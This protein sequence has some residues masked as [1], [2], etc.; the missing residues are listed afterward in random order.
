MS[1]KLI[2]SILSTLLTS[3]IFF[4]PKSAI[5]LKQLASE[6]RAEAKNP[7]HIISQNI[8]DENQGNF[9]PQNREE[10]ETYKGRMLGAG[11]FQTGGCP[12]MA[13]P[14]LTTFV[15]GNGTESFLT[16]TAE[17]APTFWFY[18]PYSK[19]F[20]SELSAEF[21][22]MDKKGGTELWTHD[23]TQYPLEKKGIFP[24]QIPQGILQQFD[25][26]YYWRFK[27]VC[28]SSQQ[29]IYV[30]GYIKRVM[31]LSR[32]DLIVGME[33]EEKVQLY[34]QNG[35]W[36]EFL[37]TY[38][39]EIC[40]EDVERTK[41]QIKLELNSKFIGL[42]EYSENYVASIINYCNPNSVK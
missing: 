21:K 8:Q 34:A 26:D 3:T 35:L 17:Q 2:S 18:S 6:N 22:L 37:T 4:L 9:L 7:A 1:I 40:P 11:S 42:G 29:Q 39:Y 24:I 14:P 33:P 13:P 38:I 30:N 41:S 5:S 10:D 15:P 27:I 31:P 19:Q 28:K 16:T 12:S 25:K 36:P 32:A 20:V 23:Y